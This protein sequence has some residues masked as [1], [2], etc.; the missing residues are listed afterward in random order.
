MFILLISVQ[1]LP[2]QVS[3]SL[4]LPDASLPPD[5]KAAVY[6]PADDKRFLARFKLFNSVQLLPL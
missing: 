6:V 2:F 1:E 4:V 5:P 3:A